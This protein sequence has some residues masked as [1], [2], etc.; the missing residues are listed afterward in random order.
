MKT[1]ILAAAF[2]LC[3]LPSF[4]QEEGSEASEEQSDAPAASEAP[5][6][7]PP[8]AAKAA[9]P[10][11]NG[12]RPGVQRG[13]PAQETPSSSGDGGQ[14]SGGGGISQG[15]RD[16]APGGG[17]RG[18][19]R[20]TADGGGSFPSTAKCEIKDLDIPRVPPGPDTTS[21]GTWSGQNLR[22][23]IPRKGCIAIKFTTGKA[24]GYYF[25]MEE[26][27]IAPLAETFINLSRAPGDFNYSNM[28]KNNGCSGSASMGALNFGVIGTA[29]GC[30]NDFCCHVSPGTV[31]YL[32]MRNESADQRAGLRG[33]DSCD[34]TMAH[35]SDPS[36]RGCGGVYQFHGW[37]EVP[38]KAAVPKAK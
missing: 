18:F 34:F 20:D 2:V 27:P 33:Q 3:A 4:A 35:R 31:Y 16:S 6:M 21:L 5:A 37:D 30:R 23:V 22:W 14:V 13:A 12:A 11:F 9:K 38:L 25:G 10:A 24:G 26:D 19:S 29:R 17:L 7:A 8:P 32:N 36:G 1:M 28:D 15:A